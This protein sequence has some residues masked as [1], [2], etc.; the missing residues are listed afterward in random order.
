MKWLLEI[1]TYFYL[2]KILEKIG[3]VKQ[4][5]NTALLVGIS[6]INGK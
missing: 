2:N 6:S 1:E 3:F 5:T 4:A